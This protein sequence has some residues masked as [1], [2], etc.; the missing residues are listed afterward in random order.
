MGRFS[1]FNKSAHLSIFIWCVPEQMGQ[2]VW[3]DKVHTQKC[4]FVNN[5]GSE[6]KSDGE[7]Q[8]MQ[9]KGK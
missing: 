1:Y 4:N 8:E 2:T 6:M 5:L 9:I 7:K 3:E